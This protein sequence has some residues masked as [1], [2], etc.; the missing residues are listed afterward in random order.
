MIKKSLHQQ[1]EI[2]YNKTDECPMTDSSFNFFQFVYV[3]SGSGSHGVN[4]NH[5][6]YK[7]GTFLLLTPNDYHIF[8]V[9]ATT[10]FL[11]IR[12]NKE[13]IK[14][15]KWKSIDHIECL[16]HN[17]SHVSGC[18]IENEND[19]PLVKSIIESIL[20]TIRNKDLYNTDLN[21]HFINALIVI[22]ARNIS[23]FKP[24]D[25]K[26]QA[27]KKILEI[28]N[29]IQSNIYL[30]KQL[31]VAILCDKFGISPNYLSVY[32]KEQCGETLSN[33]IANYRLR[34]IE[35]RLSFSD[36]RINELVEEF[37][38]ADES[39]MNKFFKR[40]KGMSLSVYRRNY[41]SL[42]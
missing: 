7:T 22:A 8:S 36:A 37:G 6:A 15:Y 17:A 23:K 10:E 42:L 35:Y 11:L 40:H 4:G 3:I 1:V 26:A 13:Y 33:F 25:I 9:E 2:L 20:Y 16:L 21:L 19:K 24:R 32:F 30:P 5:I 29:Y 31:K 28:I 39:H 27:D 18:I 14:D 38:F 12:F 34:L 41:T